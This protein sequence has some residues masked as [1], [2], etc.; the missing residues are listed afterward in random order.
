LLLIYGQR[1]GEA[2]VRRSRLFAAGAAID[3]IAQR[4]QAAPGPPRNA[5]FR[6][7]T[8]LLSPPVKRAGVS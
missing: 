5:Y 1:G 2:M 3:A 6:S 7:K 4:A 8:T